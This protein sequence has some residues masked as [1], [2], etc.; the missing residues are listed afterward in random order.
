[1]R[2]TEILYHGCIFLHHITLTFNRGVWTL[3]NHCNVCWPQYLISQHLPFSCQ[4]LRF[5]ADKKNELI[6]NVLKGNIVH[7]HRS[8]L[9]DVNE[10]NENKL[11][12]WSLNAHIFR[13]REHE[14]H[15]Q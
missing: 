3:Y 2:N 6:I 11:Q 4:E 12:S 14:E 10:S 9:A 15:N 8:V 13:L 5:S 1:M 7:Y